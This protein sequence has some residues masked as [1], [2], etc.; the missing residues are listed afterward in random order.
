MESDIIS[1]FTGPL[2]QDQVCTGEM[3]ILLLAAGT[4]EGHSLSAW[5]RRLVEAIY[6]WIE[7]LRSSPAVKRF[8]QRHPGA[9]GFIERRFSPDVYLGLHLTVGLLA[10]ILLVWIFGS[11]TEEMLEHDTLVAVD[12]WITGHISLIRSPQADRAMEVIT[13]FG[14]REVLPLGILVTV[15]LLLFMRRYIQAAGFLIANAGGYLL[16][17]ILK[18]TIQRERPLTEYTSVE[19][20]G[21][22][23][24][25]GHAMMAAIFYGMLAYFLIRAVDSRKLR[26][27]IVCIAAAAIM[28]IGFSRIYLGVHYIS[29]VAAGFAGGLFWLSVCITGLE[30]YR[31]KTAADAEHS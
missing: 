4:G 25:S 16:V 1:L 2:M 24:P 31:I 7:R 27:F 22:S 3:F 17:I 18:M 23:Y 10:S 8:K 5:V 26:V 11:I 29:D 19:V 14:G 6:A 21:Y 12:H 28:I 30:V 9:S 13:R 15:I 20:A